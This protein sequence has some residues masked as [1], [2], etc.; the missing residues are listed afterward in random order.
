MAIGIVSSPLRERKLVAPN[1]PREIAAASP[2]A[3]MAGRRR[4]GTVTS[5][6]VRLGE[7]PSV[8]A[9]SWRWGSMP[10]RTGSTVRTTNGTATSAWPTGTSHHASR[11]STGGVSNV[12]RRPKPIVTADVAIGSISP[13]SSS[14]PAR[15][16]PVMAKAASR[17]ITTATTVATAVMRR[18]AAIDATGSM[19]TLMPGR[20]SARPRVRQAPSV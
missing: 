7:A 16:A 3:A 20:T 5:H 9:A 18:D 14:R 1:S 4:C 2:A 19:P 12:I 8:A 13:V 10:R 15:R 11:Q 6:H 17:P